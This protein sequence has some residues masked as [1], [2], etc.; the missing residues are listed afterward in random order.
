MRLADQLPGLLL[1]LLLLSPVPS[2]AGEAPS[3]PP[4]QDPGAAHQAED[5]LPDIQRP[6]LRDGEILLAPYVME[7]F[8]A[9]AGRLIRSSGTAA[10]T[11]DR[12]ICWIVTD[13]VR[14]Q[15][16]VGADGIRDLD[17]SLDS[18]RPAGGAG[19]PAVA[20]M[21]SGLT[22]LIRGSW[23]EVRA[24]YRVTSSVNGPD[25]GLF[26]RPRREELAR[27]VDLVVIHLADG[28]IREFRVVENTG[29]STRVRFAPGTRILQEDPDLRSFCRTLPEAGL[30]PGGDR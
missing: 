5:V 18:P 6:L 14:R 20:F 30:P 13:P 25:T 23:D 12:G 17:A 29:G 10:V 16:L 4:P 15:W 27:V 3:D 24:D 1:P 8:L 2:G 7:R 28:E 9:A 26:L 21:I 11:L 19:D 22:T